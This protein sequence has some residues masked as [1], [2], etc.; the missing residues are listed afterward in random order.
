[1]A[2]GKTLEAPFDLLV[3]AHTTIISDA[4]DTTAEGAV[5]AGWTVT[6]SRPGFGKARADSTVEPVATSPG[7]TSKPNALFIGKVG[8]DSNLTKTDA[9]RQLDL[10]GYAGT[11]L[12]LSFRWWIRDARTSQPFIVSL[13]DD[14]GAS[15]K[16]ELMRVN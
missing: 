4:F 11:P 14:G 13:S 7:P 5:P 16:W 3:A 9:L 12:V 10:T 6:T 1:H 8:S 2:S 15:F